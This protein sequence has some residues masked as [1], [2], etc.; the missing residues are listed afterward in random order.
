MTALTSAG[1]ALPS[2]GDPQPPAD[3]VKKDHAVMFLQ[4]P[5]GKAHRR[6][7]HV[8]GLRRPGGVA[9]LLTEGEK[10]LDVSQGHGTHHLYCFSNGI[11]IIILFLLL[12]CKAYNGQEE[13][14]RTRC[15]LI[16]M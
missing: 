13:K 2:R 15:W 5:E 6:L 1:E 14:E 11:N 3:P 8:Q 16:H 4:L 10:D 9:V 7:S 12:F